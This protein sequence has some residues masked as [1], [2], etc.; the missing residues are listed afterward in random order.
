MNTRNSLSKKSGAKHPMQ[1]PLEAGR[2]AGC[3]TARLVEYQELRKGNKMPVI[4]GLQ[5]AIHT[6][7][8]TNC[9]RDVNCRGVQIYDK[10]GKLRMENRI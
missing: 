1:L 9:S 6:T 5:F 8:H 7:I 3:K 4:Q 10:L 2:K